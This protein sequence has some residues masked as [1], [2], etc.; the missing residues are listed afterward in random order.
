LGARVDVQSH[1]GNIP[2]LPAHVAA[3]EAIYHSFL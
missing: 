2:S 1:D 3:I